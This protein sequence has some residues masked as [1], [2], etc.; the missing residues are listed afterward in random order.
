MIG[1][2]S[3]EDYAAT[4]DSDTARARMAAPIGTVLKTVAG[5]GNLEDIGLRINTSMHYHSETVF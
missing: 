3:A 1:R 4:A 2:D 5:R